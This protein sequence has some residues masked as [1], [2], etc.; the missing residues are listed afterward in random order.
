MEKEIALLEFDNNKESVIMPGHEKLD[1]KLPKRAV[2]AF[3]RDTVDEYAKER[4]LE[5]VCSFETITMVF[6]V[7]VDCINGVEVAIAMAPLGG[8]AAA[9]FLDWIISYGVEEVIVTGSC[10]VLIDIPE[11][12]FLIPIRALRD[13]GTSFH[14]MKPSRFVE[15]DKELT[16]RVTGYFERNGL[17]Y[18][19]VTV[20]TTDGFFRETAD[21][22]KAR[23]EEG[24]AC[25]DMEC[26]SLSACAKFRGARLAQVFFTADCLANTSEY[27]ER[28]WGRASL[29]PALELCIK[30]A[31]TI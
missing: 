15:T 7:Y 10:G 2:F 11:N 23:V 19:K 12:E 22:V 18:E 1:I 5:S 4:G 30:I 31:T 3:V 26:A 13:E 25:V 28:D 16:E 14:Y 6:P 24:C 27:N 9:Q 17:D 20:W 8:P 21:K 29:R